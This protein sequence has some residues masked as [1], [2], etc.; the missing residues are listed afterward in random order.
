MLALQRSRH[1]GVSDS[2]ETMRQH[3]LRKQ[4][5]EYAEFLRAK[6]AASFGHSSAK[7]L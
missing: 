3:E 7:K 5:Y 6:I 2:P 1:F 4:F